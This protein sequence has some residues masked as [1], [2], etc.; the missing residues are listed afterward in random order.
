MR[1]GK[2]AAVATAVVL[3]SLTAAGPAQAAVGADSGVYTESD[4]C[5]WLS[6]NDF[7]GASGSADDGD[8]TVT[9]YTAKA[10]DLYAFAA[11]SGSVERYDKVWIDRSVN[12]FV[13]GSDASHPSD[14]EVQAN[15]G[16]K[17]CGPYEATWWNAA[18]DYFESPTVQ[19]QAGGGKSYAV[20][21]CMRPHDSDK[22]TCAPWF[23]DHG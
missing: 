18:W 17:Q 10:T 22:S 7:V 12:P 6:N 1:I 3:C 19:L 9:T 16:W 8:R 13:M 23:V 2:G 5:D 4:Q 15:G 21:A 11:I 14:D 20:R